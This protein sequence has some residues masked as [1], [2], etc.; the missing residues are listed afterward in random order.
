VFRKI[1]LFLLL[2]F[3]SV[4]CFAQLGA[5]TERTALNSI[6]KKNWEKAHVQLIKAVNKDSLNTIARYIYALYFFSPENPAFQVDSAYIYNEQ[7]LQD[8]QHATPRDKDHMKRYDLD[9][10]VL[11]NLR[12]KLD[13]AAFSSANAVNTEEIYLH[14]L[15]K[16]Q[17]AE[18]RLQAIALRDEVAYREAEK[19]NS[20][21]AFSTFLHK[22]P[23]SAW[24]EKAQKNYDRLLYDSKTN[25]KRLVSYENFLKHYS[26]S[27]YIKDVEKNIF[28]LSTASGESTD[29]I[30]FLNKYPGSYFANEA[31][32]IFY[33][34]LREQENP[35]WSQLVMTDSLKEIHKLDGSFLVPILVAGKFGFMDSQGNTVI[36]PSLTEIKQDYQCGNINEDIIVLQNKILSRN[37]KEIY[38]GP[39]SAIDDLGSGFLKITN[40]QCFKVIHKSG[41]IVNDCVDDAKVIANRNL[42]L[43][44]NNRWKLY[45]FAGRE[46]LSDSW[47]EIIAHKDVYILKRDSKYVL[48]RYAD[49]I[50]ALDQQTPFFSE[51]YDEVKLWPNNLIWVR[52]KSF[53]GIVDQQLTYVI[54]LNDHELTT[55]FFGVVAKSMAGFSIYNWVGKGASYFQSI[56]IN[57][58]WLAV[59]K[60]NEWHLFDAQSSNYESK[61]YDSLKFIGPFVE[62]FLKDSVSI[63]FS[64]HL[65]Q[66]ILKPDDVVFIPGKDTISYLQ[67]DQQ[68][69][70]W[71]YSSSG[72]K[73]PAPQYEDVQS[74]GSALFIISKKD[75]KGL[76][77]K[78]GKV[79]LPPEYDAIANAGTG[80]VSILKNKKFGI[81]NVGKDKLI[82]PLFDKNPAVYANDI[83]TVYKEGFA[84]FITWDNKPLSKFEFQQIQF[85]SDSIAL[86]KRN[87]IWQLL[88]LN[89]KK[90]VEDNI[91]KINIIRDTPLE[92][93][94][95][96]QQ[97]NNYGVIS[98]ARSIIIPVTY[99]DI[100]NL[101][102][103]DE[104]LYFTEKHVTEASIF[105]VI[106][107]DESGK[108]LLRQV[109]EEDEYERIYC[110]D[111]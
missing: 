98:S 5:S 86:V 55:H 62:G 92:K 108:M 76:V 94:A 13:S 50:S 74:A 32:N 56:K 105:V 66:K 15:E 53:Q 2:I 34:L 1:T 99:S 51:Q 64:K 43:K 44:H 107:Y 72:G 79:L 21:E 60:E 42:I 65:V 110:S 16:H 45:T 84:G 8:Y 83:L 78:E 59:Q 31:R 89:S 4:A 70:K 39:I 9:S 85:W 47:D 97:G 41:F 37:G 57:E 6:R 20:Y 102:S 36:K 38:S 19:I 58:P 88:N 24:E 93:I 68:G 90:I 30:S 28:E 3:V 61:A 103:Q 87:N 82:K 77:S 40:G 71:I 109:Y 91:R 29:F 12:K 73:F 22:Y 104:P 33:H 95:I 35:V 49:L 18:Q 26:S 96:I 81:Y 54:N 27:P 23:G 80:I 63:H 10:A 11:I 106:Y 111:N 67:I 69:K 14:F 46:I 48:I 7:A 17:Y 100:V 52:T 101:G 75:K 25:D